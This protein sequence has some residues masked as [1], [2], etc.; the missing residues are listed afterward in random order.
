M[1]NK[2]KNYLEIIAEKAERNKQNDAQDDREQIQP[3]SQRQPDAERSTYEYFM[4]KE[5]YGSAL[6]CLELL[7]QKYVFGKWAYK[8]MEYVR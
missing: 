6:I 2:K 8:Y 4:N 5:D 7:K 3:Q 1:D